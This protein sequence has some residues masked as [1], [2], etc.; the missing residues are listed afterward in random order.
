[1]Y[2]YRFRHMHVH[3]QLHATS[4]LQPPHMYWSY[5]Q[6]VFSSEGEDVNNAEKLHSKCGLL[7]CKHRALYG[8][9]TWQF[10]LVLCR[11]D[12]INVL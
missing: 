4:Q 1:M 9:S 7:V 8:S 2:M 5:L 11:C 12:D 10:S 3:V 6:K